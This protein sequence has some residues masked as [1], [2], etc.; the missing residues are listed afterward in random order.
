MNA[1]ELLTFAK[2]SEITYENPDTSVKK[3]GMFGYSVVKFFD[4]DGAQAYFLTNGTNNVLSF[5][6]TEVKEKSDVV[7]DLKM[8]KVFE[9]DQRSGTSNGEVHRGFRDELDKVWPDIQAQL[10][11]SL[12]TLPL[13]ITGHSLGAAMATIAASRISNKVEALVTFGSPRVGTKAFTENSKVVHFRV[14]NNNDDVPKVP[15]LLFGFRHH[16]TNVYLTYNGKIK[17]YNIW[18]RITDMLLSRKKALLKGE[19]FKGIK[20]HMMSNYIKKLSNLT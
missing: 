6:G 7:A 4:K 13:Y 10:T 15:P 14:Q 8:R 9:I 3:F 17:E 19:R 11:A 18:Q 5:R 12:S 2:I 20:D 16:G 1:N